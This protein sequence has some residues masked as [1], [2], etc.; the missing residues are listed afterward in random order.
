MRNF[1]TELFLG[2]SFNLKPYWD[3]FRNLSANSTLNGPFVV[4]NFLH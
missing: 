3:T 4:E 1:I 2:I